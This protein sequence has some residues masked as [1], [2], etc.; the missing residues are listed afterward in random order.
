[1][2]ISLGDLGAITGKVS[3]RRNLVVAMNH[4]TGV[5]VYRPSLSAHNYRTPHVRLSVSVAS[6]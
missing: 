2:Q 1:M 3:A 4:T 5:L 6:D